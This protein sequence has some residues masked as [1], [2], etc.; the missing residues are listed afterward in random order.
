MSKLIGML[1]NLSDM[2]WS[3]YGGFTPDLFSFTLLAQNVTSTQATNETLGALIEFIY[4]TAGANGH[5]VQVSS[6][7]FPS[8]YDWFSSSFDADGNVP[9]GINKEITSRFMYRD[10][11][12]EDPDKVAD[13]LWALSAPGIYM[14]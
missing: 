1:G 7:L 8:F 14:K 3:G 5:L 9:E 12:K 6:S 11:A 13:I 10:M 2:G 4:Q